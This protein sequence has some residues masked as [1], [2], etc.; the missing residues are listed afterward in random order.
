[1]SASFF[2]G[3]EGQ[4]QANLIVA[5]NNCRMTCMNLHK[6]LVFLCMTNFFLKTKTV[7]ENSVLCHAVDKVRLIIQRVL[8][9]PCLNLIT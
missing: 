6:Y 3:F 9:K 2:P 1:M 7:R 8:L 4:M 5:C